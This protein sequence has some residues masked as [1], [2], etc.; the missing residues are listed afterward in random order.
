MLLRLRLRLWSWND[1]VDRGETAYPSILGQFGVPHLENTRNRCAII[2]CFF[3]GDFP[4][5][6]NDLS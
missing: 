1:R 4:I 3:V 2:N 6:G 5:I